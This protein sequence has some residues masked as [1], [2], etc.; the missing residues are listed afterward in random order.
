M[1]GKV[2]RDD[3]PLQSSEAERH[4]LVAQGGL[5]APLTARLFEKAGLRSGMRVLDIGSGSGDV[6]LLAARFVGPDGSV[7]G[8]DRDPAQVAFAQ[9]RADAAGL[10]NVRFVTTDFRE[11]ELRPAVDAIV[12]RLVL[13][14]AP[15]P[16]E[17]LR[18][19]L[20]NLRA[21]GVIALQESVI[22]YD[23]PVLI[24]PPDCLA[25]KVVGWFR[26]GFKHAGVH[27]RMGLRLFGLMRTAGLEPA[28]EI[29]MLVPIQQGPEGA[30]FS[31]LTSVVRSQ[32]P[33]IVASGIA[34]EAEI[35]I[36]TL[37]QRLVADA[38]ATGVV[39]YFNSGHVGVWAKKP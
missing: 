20:R 39:G 36:E 12:G 11:I 27:P 35:D 1:D 21:G 7:T 29:D 23:G 24:E 5:V 8:V 16:L 30:L 10:R 31:T 37:E 2:T 33:A 26:A 18:R 9:R 13:M 4:R 15:D 34:T 22:E 28:P 17:A 25:A 38:P 6:S 32:I 14:Y 3:Y 19:V